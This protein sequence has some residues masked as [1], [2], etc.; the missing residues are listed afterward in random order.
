MAQGKVKANEIE[1]WWEDFGDRS[2]PTV[3][4]IMGATAQAVVW[5]PEFYEPLVGAGYHV[6]RF[7][8]RDIGLSTWIDYQKAPYNLNNMAAD[9]VALMT[10]LAIQRAHVIGASM[11]GMIA[12]LVALD[13]PERVRS[14]TAIMSSPSFKDAELPGMTKEVAAAVEAL[15]TLAQTDLIGALI[16]LWRNLVGSRFGFNEEEFRARIAEW[17]ARGQNPACAHAL[18]VEKTPSWRERLKGLK[19]PTLVIHGDEDPILPLPHGEAIAQAVPG[20]KL[21]VIKGV[22]HE[23]PPGIMPEIHQ[24]ILNHLSRNA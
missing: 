15:P 12:Q 9:T 8:N 19:T 13:Y 17:I 2:N 6:V 5:T 14:L 18:A 21:Y 10:K 11:G 23:L 22:G 24:E 20:A 4:L 1:I 3:L 7:D 16:G